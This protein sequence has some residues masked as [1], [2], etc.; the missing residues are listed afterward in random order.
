DLD[1]LVEDA[2]QMRRRSLFQKFEKK[3]W[4]EIKQA[5]ERWWQFE[6]SILL[7]VLEALK[8]QARTYEAPRLTLPDAKPSE[9]AVLL[10]T[11]DLHFGK[12]GWQP[13]TGRGS[14]RETARARRIA[15]VKA[16]LARILRYG[17]PARFLVVIGGDDEHLDTDG[18]TTTGGTPQDRD[19]SPA[20][21]LIEYGGLLIDYL[22]LIRQ[23]GASV[24]VYV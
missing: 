19:G 23:T 22:E 1:D 18:G 20:Q 8:E 12:Y 4:A 15:T 3:K 13:E 11:A 9:T 21:L 5:A 6:Q 16:L 10:S 17:T 24:E 7:P 2:L 14:D